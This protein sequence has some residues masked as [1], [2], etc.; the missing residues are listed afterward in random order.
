MPEASWATS[1][2][3]LYTVLIDETL[4]PL[5]SRE[6]LHAFNQVKVQTRPLWRPIHT[7]PAHQSSIRVGGDT[8]EQLC[9]LSLS[10]PCSVG[11][12]QEDQ[13]RVITYLQEWLV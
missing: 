1:T 11:L 12:E 8:A 4:S 10:L 3:W 13:E 2:F 6:L 9:R 5:S 7:S